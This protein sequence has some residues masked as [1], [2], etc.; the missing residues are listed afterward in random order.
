VVKNTMPQ[1]D[2]SDL[3]QHPLLTM[4]QPVGDVALLLIASA[5]VFFFGWAI[6]RYR[7][8]GGVFLL[9]LVAALAS[10]GMEGWAEFM[11][12]NYHPEI[13]GHIAYEGVGMPVPIHIVLSYALY[14]GA[15]S[16]FIMLAIQRGKSTRWWW[17]L[18][19]I[20]CIGVGL[21]DIV[22]L[23]LDAWIYYGPQP[24]VLF[25]LPLWVMFCN[26]AT[27]FAFSVVV[28]VCLIRLTGM[29]RLWMI[30]I[31]PIGLSMGWA[32]I[33]LPIANALHGHAGPVLTAVFACWTILAC[34]LIAHL[35]I[36][37]FH[38]VASV[39]VII[40][41]PAATDQQ[42]HHAVVVDRV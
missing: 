14:F 9:M 1:A 27:I 16:Y 26:A 40:T 35:A 33:C 23:Q 41:N 29:Q 13:G 6:V 39:S 4:P 8:T 22:A 34:L 36:G 24:F 11:A 42:R 15:P 17:Q 2:Y 37:Y 30:F 3:L 19:A 25:K 20:N 21:A 10:S 28:H 31:A 32:A 18:F 7:A 38:S 12:M 5:V